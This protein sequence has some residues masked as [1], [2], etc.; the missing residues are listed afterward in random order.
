MISNERVEKAMHY[1]VD[2][3]DS[4]ARALD[5][6]KKLHSTEKTVLGYEYLKATGTV[7]EREATAATSNG[8]SEHLEKVEDAWADHKYLENKRA[9]EKIVIDMYRTLSANQRNG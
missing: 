2:T 5:L 4:S 9:T 6:V 7:A 8:Y 3:D 1:L